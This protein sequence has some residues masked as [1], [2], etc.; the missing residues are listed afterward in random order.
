MVR[1]L[2]LALWLAA[3]CAL[4]A[5][6]AP[7]AVRYDIR[8]V[9]RAGALSA[10]AVEMRFAGD[11]SGRTRLLLP[12]QGAARDGARPDLED[13]EV[14]G[15][16]VANVDGAVET[17]AGAPGAAIVVRYRIVSG[18]DSVPGD[19]PLRALLLADWFA[20]HGE[21]AFIRPQGRDAAAVSVRF[22]GLPEGWI[23]ASDLGHGA[24]ATVGDLDE[25]YFIGGAG[26]RE[27]GRPV[28]AARLR[29]YDR[30]DAAPKAVEAGA[31]LAARIAA[32]E[33]DYWG[34]RPW[35]IFTPVI[36]LKDNTGGRG[37]MHGF[38]FFAG[39]G[40]DLSTFKHDLAHEM[41]HAWT[42]RQIGGFPAVDPDLEAWLNEGF[43]ELTADRILLRA[44]LWT[45]T[46]YVA[47]LNASLLSYGTSPVREAPNSRIQADRFSDL[48]VGRLPYDRGRLLG[49]IW[50]RQLR[51]ATGGRVGLQ[52]VLQV[53]RRLAL[54]ERA[55][56]RA[57]SAD[58]LF[59]IAV[60]QASGL[61]LRPDIAKYVDDGGL[62]TFPS[63][64]LRPCGVFETV[65]QPVFDRGFDIWATLRN[66]RRLT[67]L[68]P[69]GPA[70]RAGLREGEVIGMDEV[71]S[72]DSQKPLTY[73]VTGA[74][75]VRRAITF[76]PEGKGVVSFQQFRL[77]PG[78]DP[79]AQ[80]H[81]AAIF[82]GAA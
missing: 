45:L 64:L 34:D 63:G 40:D 36:P 4:G 68:E 56:G 79:A 50:D 19:Q 57:T 54:A 66:G 48:D 37:M 77:D 28:G 76:K 62:V 46:D 52:D 20:V 35:D 44:G 53:Q 70:D 6:A 31:D 29:L 41:E 80:A 71:P 8:P 49:L 16:A 13:V 65:S 11:A 25:R 10:L 67:G 21:R 26:W 55:A 59:P 9:L 7:S 75:G 51:A 47:G 61:D 32:A 82:S 38:I 14:E 81:C 5:R 23:A 3:D 73:W 30:A 60:L 17:L 39:P 74:D 58:R 43:T 2:V 78:L 42:S 1:Q 12:K 27:I 22:D 24:G 33:F 15:A 72:N 69:G 18:Y